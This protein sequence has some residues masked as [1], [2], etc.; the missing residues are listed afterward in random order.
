M[1]LRVIGVVR[2]PPPKT[3]A[4]PRFVTTRLRITSH[5]GVEIDHP[6]FVEMMARAVG[7]GDARARRPRAG[8]G[9]PLPLMK[10]GCAGLR[11]HRTAGR[12]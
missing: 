6:F 1:G 4:D 8:Y 9:S 11:Y 12:Y 2:F 5:A 10:T 3:V 7:D